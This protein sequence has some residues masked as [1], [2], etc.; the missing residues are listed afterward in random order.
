MKWLFGLSESANFTQHTNLS[1]KSVFGL[2]FRCIL[3]EDLQSG[4]KLETNVTLLHIKLALQIYN[5]M[6]CDFIAA[7]MVTD[8]EKLHGCFQHP[9]PWQQRWSDVLLHYISEELTWYGSWCW[10]SWWLLSSTNCED[11]AANLWL[12]LYLPDSAHF[13]PCLCNSNAVPIM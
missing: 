4:S 6:A 13:H 5:A 9:L 11:R 1:K 8:A 10:K 12:R 3:P 7:A 2:D